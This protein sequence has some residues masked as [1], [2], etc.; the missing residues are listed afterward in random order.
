MSNSHKAGMPPARADQ[1]P[2]TAYAVLGLLAFGPELSGYDLKQWADNLRFFYWSPAHSQI[3]AELR[4]LEERGL[5][6]SR[7]V[8]QAHRPDKRLYRITQA[9]LAEARRWL[10]QGPVEPPVLKHSIVL[11]LF[12]GHLTQPERLITIL[13]DYAASLEQS[14][15]ELTAVHEGL[16]DSE[17][18]RFPALC[19][20]WG[21]AY[22]QAELTIARQLAKQLAAQQ[23]PPQPAAEGPP[24]S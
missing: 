19:A 5:V 9:G 20:E 14:L 1:L 3:Y 12:F 21:E 13:N 11:R 6:T 17:Q 8:P 23:Q 24:S 16:G 22:Y 18:F 15:A 7:Q 4:R 2:N 10:D